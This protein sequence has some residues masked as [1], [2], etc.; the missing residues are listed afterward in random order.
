[1]A[2]FDTARPAGLV[3]NAQRIGGMFV[4]AFGAVSAWNDVRVT[5]NTLETLTNRQLEDIGLTR[6]DI[7]RVAKR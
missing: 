3:G 7:D 6:G 1:M 2:L 4:S 5:R